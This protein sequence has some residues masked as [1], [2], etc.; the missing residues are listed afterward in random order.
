M[1]TAIK[2]W[3]IIIVSLAVSCKKQ[4]L[5]ERDYIRY[6]EENENGLVKT[7]DIGDLR[8]KVQYKPHDYILAHEL[9]GGNDSERLSRLNQMKGTAWFNITI[10]RPGKGES[11]LR[12]NVSSLEEYN[13]RYNYFLTAAARD[14]ALAYG[15]DTLF[16]I[17]YHFE[18]SY[19][20]APVETMIVGFGL[21]ADSV[22]GQNMQLIFYDRVFNNGIIKTSFTKESLQSI[23]Q[24][25]L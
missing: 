25:T 20:L 22:A 18:T 11:P 12:Y 2:F 16:P 1:K 13:H 6:V 24:V 4:T 9:K 15:G 17:S 8:Y 14:L 7:V 3:C 10:A 5:S 23:P 19:N 21:P